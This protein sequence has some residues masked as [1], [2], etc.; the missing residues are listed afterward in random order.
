M[1]LPKM[2]VETTIGEIA[3]TKLG[4]M[5]DGAKNKGEPTAY[6][7]NISVRWG[8]FDLHDL[9]TMP[10]TPDELSALAVRD[11]DLFVCEGGV[12]GRCA[13]WRGGAQRI[14]FQKAIH[15]IRP[16]GGISADFL[17]RF[18]VWSAG[19]DAFDHL[20]TGT[21]I[22]HLPQVGLQRITLPLPPLAEQRRIV[23]KLDTLAARVTRARTEI[24]RVATMATSM[25]LAEL[26]AIFDKFKDGPKA[27]IDSVCKV[28]T[29]STPKRGHAPF[30]EGGHI[31]WV[32][33]G[34]VN[35]GTVNR[36]TEFITQAA[37][38]ATNCKVFPAGSLLVAL[39]GEGK[40]RGKVATLQIE[41][42][43][44]QALA[45]LHG[46]DN[47]RVTPRWIEFFLL[48]RYEETREQ[49]A[50]G[51][52]PNLNLGIVKAIT[53]PL[54]PIVD[55]KSAVSTLDLAFARADRLEAEVARA[56]VLLDRLEAAILARAFRGELV[57]Q[58]PTDECASVLLDRIRTERAA[59][60]TAK[61][62]RVK[63]AA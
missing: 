9:P 63:E 5:L 13:V 19:N 55:Q 25:R 8:S 42:A 60:S 59:A 53:L 3:E 46:F 49:A 16:L 33:S 48:G 17:Q 30:Y 41:A 2:W 36:P 1:T 18:I 45:V 22:K 20:L 32:T 50:G 26:K 40:T 24:D 58:D 61:R 47:D 10:V 35:Q 31:P 15:R 62:G 56:R 43:T 28:G 37:I 51:V 7:R 52:Q 6:L 23:A 11:G 4:K 44:N 57:Q 14:V 12:P 34:V 27:R 38:R 29:G 21:T 54:P 39:Y